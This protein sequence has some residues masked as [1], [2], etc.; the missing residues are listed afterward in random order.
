MP[1]I[2]CCPITDIPCD[3]GN[4]RLDRCHLQVLEAA[5]RAAIRWHGDP[6]TVTP[7]PPLS[8]EI[9]LMSLSTICHTGIYMPA[10]TIEWAFWRFDK[11]SE[12]VVADVKTADFRRLLTVLREVSPPYIVAVGDTWRMSGRET[13]RA[14]GISAHLLGTDKTAPSKTFIDDRPQ[15]EN[16]LVDV[17][18]DVRLRAMLPELGATN[19][20]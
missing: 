20:C 16:K 18:L 9:D 8:I 3:D 17:R 13:I 6:R 4:C 15:P 19:R 2:P 7:A 1:R 12:P 14:A 10:E 5:G 11:P